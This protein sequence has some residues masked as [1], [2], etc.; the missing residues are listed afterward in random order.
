MTTGSKDPAA[1]IPDKEYFKIGEVARVV[2]VPAHVLRFWEGEFRRDV[3]P[4]RTRGN[5][6]V[7]RRRD[8]EAFLRIKALR[9][10]ERL[11]IGGAKRRLRVD[12]GEEI[13]GRVQRL[14][15]RLGEELRELLRIVDEDEAGE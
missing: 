12:S 9:Y 7:Y 13:A 1:A 3:R 11:E 5:Q 2:G 8:I 14:S 10:D 15:E 4:E 6:R